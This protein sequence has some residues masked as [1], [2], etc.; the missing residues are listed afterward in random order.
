MAAGANQH[1]L[2]RFLQKPFG[3]L[4]KRKDIWVFRKSAAPCL[5]PIKKVGSEN[6]FYSMVEETGS[7]TL[8]DRITD[9]E[10]ALSR[11]LN[12]IRSLP[13][14]ASVASVVAAEVVFHLTQRMAHFRSLL[15]EAGTQISKT[16]SE[17][18]SDDQWVGNAI[19]TRVAQRLDEHLTLSSEDG[20]ERVSSELLKQIVFPHLQEHLD[21]AVA[22]TRT[23]AH[24]LGEFLED[25]PG[26]IREAHND[27]IGD[28]KPTPRQQFLENL[29]WVV[30]SAPNHQ[31]ILPDCVAFAILRDGSS[32]PYMISDQGQTDAVIMPV[33][34]SKLLVG[35][36]PRFVFCAEYDFNA[37]AARASYNFFLA[38][39]N[40]PACGRIQPL[41]GEC[42]AIIRAAG[43]EAFTS[44]YSR[45][46]STK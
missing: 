10:T 29:N 6:Y 36:T 39:T 43:R 35:Y 16:L 14:A 8:D 3:S 33:S 26:M 44:A 41:I 2:P 37:A 4:P 42:T 7:P 22:V 15:G 40:D 31:A 13:F 20:R 30:Q 5:R 32:E 25:S 18:V 12:E 46:S 38:S 27:A 23:L 1:F 24:G 19:W 21:K 11:K 45:Y 17:L 28:F 34:P 9:I